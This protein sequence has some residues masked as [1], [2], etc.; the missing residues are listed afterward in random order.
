MKKVLIH[1]FSGTGNTYHMV[2]VIGDRIKQQGYEVVYNNI[3]LGNAEQ[4]KDIALHI[5]SYPVYAFGT[6]SIVLRY[7][8]NLKPV[9]Q[10][11]A[12][13][14]CS[15]YEYEGQSLAHVSSILNRKGY[16]V[17][18]T[19]IGIY[20][21]NWTQIANPVEEKLQ[22]KV[23]EATDKSML[24][25]ADKITTFQVS[26]RKCSKLNLPWTWFVFSLFNIAGRRILGKTFIADKSCVSCKK[27]IKG[28]PA[29]AIRLSKGKPKWNWKCENCQRCINMCPNSSIQ[30]SPMRL[31][32]FVLIAIGLLFG[33][34]SFNQHHKQ[35]FLLNIFLYGV[36]YLA[37]T[38]FIDIIMNALEKIPLVR[39]IFE[40]SYTKK[41]RRYFVKDFLKN[42]L[43]RLP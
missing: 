31:S 1:F 23:V 33:I 21:Q 30:T 35:P 26:F 32:L 4:V 42:Y 43:S 7:L 27:C 8:K 9:E 24:E 11:K 3:E 29:K 10:C 14:I 16:D 41:Y 39:S 19:D 40:Y 13:V 18:L 37:L 5:F 6:P 34:F 2:N 22:S 25:L 28:C 38:F 15:C 36:I 17:F 20:P 12:A